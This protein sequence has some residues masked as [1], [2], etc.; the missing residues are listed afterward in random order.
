MNRIARLF[1]A[2]LFTIGALTSIPRLTI[3]AETTEGDYSIVYRFRQKFTGAYLYT[4]SVNERDTIIKNLS[5]QWEF[6]GSKFTV[7][8]IQL[9]ASVPVYRFFNTKTGAHFQTS[10]ED[11][12]NNIINNLKDFSFEGIKYYVYESSQPDTVGI[13]RFFNTKKN[14]HLFTA[15]EAEKNDIINNLSA[16]WKYEGT[17]N[18]TNQLDK[19]LSSYSNSEYIPFSF[20]YSGTLG[21][22]VMTQLQTQ[23][24]IDD[25]G[26]MEYVVAPRFL[27]TDGISNEE[28]AFSIS[29]MGPL[30]GGGSLENYDFIEEFNLTTKSGENMKFKAWKHKIETN[31]IFLSFGY[32]NVNGLETIS[33]MQI[34]DFLSYPL[35]K[36]EL[37][38]I[39]GSL[40][41]EF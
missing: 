2:G 17:F 22:P 25:D 40:S 3:Q 20:N 30:G 28:F 35:L 27:W 1:L 36:D 32:T 34:V 4:R 29:T 24:D 41:V 5:N 9:E 10:N 13:H 38:I 14:I 23:F 7:M 33:A 11:E 19:A 37:V 31:K 15:S 21:E 26:D 18:Y 8:S 12:K 16:E 39:F 6:E